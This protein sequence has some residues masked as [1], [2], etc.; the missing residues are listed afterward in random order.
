[1]II[2]SPLK[3]AL[4]TATIVANELGY[5]QKVEIDGAMR[6]EATYAL[7]QALVKKHASV[8]SLMVVGHNPSIRNFLSRII[9]RQGHQTAIE[10]KKGAVA[11][12]EL[13][14][15]EGT[16]HWLL[17]PKLVGNIHSL[18]KSSLPKTSRK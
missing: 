13:K 18:S 14:R 8:E 5:E 16:L 4:Q 17:T 6:P 10:F 9:G 15:L 2:S 1:M 3:R 7:F 11:K 12:V